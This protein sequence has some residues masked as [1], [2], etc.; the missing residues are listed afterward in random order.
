M[1]INRIQLTNFR[2][3]EALDLSFDDGLTILTGENAQGKTN[4]LEAIFL[5]AMAKSH[6]TNNDKELIQWDKDSARIIGDIETKNYTFPLEIQISKKGK[7]V[8][9]NHI[10]QA[11]L[12]SF[13]GKFNVVLFSPEDLQI[14]KGSPSLRRKFLDAELAQ[15]HPVYLQE[16]LD[17][18]Q[19]LKQ[20]NKYLKEYGYQE[21]FDDLYFDVMTDQLISKAVNII[22]YRTSFIEKLNTYAKE[23]HH[24]LSNER[25]ELRLDYISSSSK[26]DY[27]NI[28]TLTVQFKTLFESALK[29]ERE[30]GVTVY[31]PHRDD[32]AFLLNGKLASNFGSQGQQRTIVL[33]VKLAEIEL[34]KDL[35]GE[36]PVLLLDDVLSELD[37]QR[38]HLLMRRIEGKIQTFITSATIEGL[39]LDQL[40]NL[41]LYYVEAG[42]VVNQ[43]KGV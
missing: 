38:Q 42:Q 19:I 30:Q 35:L 26:L 36:Y 33:S 32:L 6:R 17:Y 7:K 39:E 43:S 27:N 9:V 18:H 31:G 29:R 11:K 4:L 3:Y 10:D 25:D 41:D 34:L 16:L 13:I 14:I 40:E 23:I 12:S 1:K 21:L 24:D 22:Q 5:L 20:R 15:S 37:D 28:E 2:N 8:R